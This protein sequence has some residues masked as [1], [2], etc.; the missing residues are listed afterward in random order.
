[1]L[2]DPCKY[3]FFE[4]EVIVFRAAVHDFFPL[5][6]TTS[7]GEKEERSEAVS[8]ARRDDDLSWIPAAVTNA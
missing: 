8:V 7:L 3:P 5:S 2:F 4:S 6:D 1:M